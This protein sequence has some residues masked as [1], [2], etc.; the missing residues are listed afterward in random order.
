M[1]IT[2]LIAGGLGA[3]GSIGSAIIGSN[4]SQKA[5]QAQVAMGQ[6]ALAQQ[7]A[8][9]QQG[10]GVATG[11]LEPYITAGQGVLPTLRGLIA[12]GPNQNALLARTPGFQFQSQYGTMAAKNALAAQGLGASAGPV[13]TAISNY[14]QGLAGT[15]WGNVVNALQRYAGLGA[16]A[17]E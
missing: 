14:N 5:S 6:E 12:P 17:G 2:A 11:A 10:L 1:G 4:A 7:N 8:L 9:Y 15:T 3:V 16:S 13:A